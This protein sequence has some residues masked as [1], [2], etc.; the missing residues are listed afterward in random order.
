[1]TDLDLKNVDEP[2]KS[3]DVLTTFDTAVFGS[4]METDGGI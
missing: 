3:G 4:Q 2:A 1:M